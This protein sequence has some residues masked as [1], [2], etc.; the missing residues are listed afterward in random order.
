MEDIRCPADPPQLYNLSK[1]PK[2][3]INLTTSTD[4]E[5]QKVFKAF[6][7]EADAK[8]DL[9]A[10]TDDVLAQQRRR[11]FVA[12]ALKQGRYESWDYKVPENSQN[13]YI[14]SHMDLDDLEL[15]AR[16]PQVDMNGHARTGAKPNQGKI[17]HGQAGAVGQ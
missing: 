1:D 5:D 10:I 13:K 11:R 12:A 7:D 14:R 4:A 6:E 2:E 15:R 3:L 9:Q 8:W 17:M 16:Y